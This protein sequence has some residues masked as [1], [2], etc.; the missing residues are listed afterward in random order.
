MDLDEVLDQ[1][2]KLVTPTDEEV[3]KAKSVEAK[4]RDRLNAV[5]KKHPNLEYRFLG[6]YPRNTWLRGNLEID[7]FLLFPEETSIEELEKTGLEI[8]K[9]VVDEYELRFASHPYVHGRIDGVDVDVVPCY[10]LESAERIKSAVDRTPFHHDWLENRVKGKEGDVR[11]LKMFLKAGNI[12]GAEYKVKGF[13]GYLCELL[14][15]YYGSFLDV[16]KNALNWTRD[17]VIDIPNGRVYRKKGTKFFVVDPVDPKRNVS[18]NL[19][20]DNLAKFVQMCRDFLEKPSLNFFKRKTIVPNKEILKAE[21]QR[22]GTSLLLVKFRRPDVVEDNLYTQLE[23]AC[24]RIENFLR[25]KEFMPLRSGFVADDENCYLVFETQI[26]ELSRIYRHRGPIF[27][28]ENNVKRFLSKNPR[29]FIEDGRFW[30]FRERRF[31]RPEEAVKWILTNEWK[32]MG[33]NV[34]EVL[35]REF[36]LLKGLEVLEVESTDLMVFLNDFLGVAFD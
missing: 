19:S 9:A 4:L 23:K 13:S 1:A 22:R 25:D 28:D 24:R 36:E 5:L 35:K 21:I 27:E 30:V 3:R 14:V 20:L 8:G 2:L 34:G 26:K 18:A 16:V 33:K 10:R 29:Y 15:V 6:S 32:S 11:L 7:V 12:Y 31:L 17:T